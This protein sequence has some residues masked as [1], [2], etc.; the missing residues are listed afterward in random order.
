MKSKIIVLAFLVGISLTLKAQNFDKQKLDSLFSIIEGNERGMGSISIF[1]DGKEVYQKSYGYADVENKVRNNA[2]TKFRV[3]SISKTFTAT[4]IMK[5]IENKKLSLDSKLSEFYPQIKNADKI[6]IAD[7]LQHRSG[8]ANFIGVTDYM[9]W[10]T[11]EHTKEQLLQRIASGNT[12]FE[13]GERFEYSNSNYTLLAFIAEDI[14]K[15]KFSDLLQEIIIKPCLLENTSPGNKINVSNNEALSYKKLSKWTLEDETDMSILLGA[16]SIISTPFDLNVFLNCLFTLKIINEE[17][18]KQMITLKDGF[19][20]GLVQ[21]PFYEMKAYG[22]TGG[23]DGFR[24]NAFYFP[25]EKVSV[26]LT[27]NG[28]VYPLNDILIGALSIYFG[29]EFQ[30]PAFKESIILTTEEL[31][32]YT[33]VYSADSF[34]L[35]ITVSRDDN[36]LV[37][38][39]TGQPSFRLECV[40]KNKFEYDQAQVEKEI[41]PPEDKMI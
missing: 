13:P 9:Q 39:G 35:E 14:A 8:I 6:T 11:V 20:F 18:L 41:I 1:Q 30:F 33:G 31:N 37:A 34:P 32:S 23:L 3:G 2:S 15:K 24:S 27:S 5:L 12:S 40:G 22:H 10:N 4:V 36:I 28:V 16:G 26:A 25:E 19:G 29:K 7:L 17:S 38:Q 21:V